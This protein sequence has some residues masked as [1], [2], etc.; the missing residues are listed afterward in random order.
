[1]VIGIEEQFK[2]IGCC[3][4]RVLTL[5]DMEVSRKN[6]GCEDYVAQENFEKL[7]CWLYP[8]AFTMSRVLVNSLWCST[9]PKWIKG[10]ITNKEAEQSLQ[11]PRGMQEPETLLLRFPTS[12][13]WPHQ[14]VGSL[15]VTY[16]GRDYTIH[17]MLL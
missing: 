4:T 12:R 16:V 7:W 14:D 11:V 3:N 13:S 8:V 5:K 6:A 15:V 9:S 1:M 10:F 2:R 17:H